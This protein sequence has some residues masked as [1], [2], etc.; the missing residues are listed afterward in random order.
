MRRRLS[1]D[2]FGER[3]HKNEEEEGNNSGLKTI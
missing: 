2:D 3:K 1:S